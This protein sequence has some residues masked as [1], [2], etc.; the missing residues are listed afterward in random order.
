LGCKLSDFVRL[1]TGN[2]SKIGSR[3]S[4]KFLL[5]VLVCI[6]ALGGEIG[7]I[8]LSGIAKISKF[9]FNCIFFS[10]LEILE[11][12]TEFE[13][14]GVTISDSDS[15]PS[16]NILPTS[17]SFASENIEPVDESS[18]SKEIKYLF[19]DIYYIYISY[20]ICCTLG[21]NCKFKKPHLRKN[22]WK[23]LK[24]ENFGIFLQYK[25]R[26]KIKID[27]LGMRRKKF[28]LAHDE[29]RLILP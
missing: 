7:A 28:H 2:S 27:G 25:C 20:N 10:G 8:S 15:V 19:S 18:I 5:G 22:K 4:S 26:L 24:S 21:L 11:I 3:G 9:S 16:E 1:C 14:G 29:A 17:E 13:D 6:T 12:N 23:K